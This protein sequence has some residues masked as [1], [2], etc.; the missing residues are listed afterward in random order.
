M[1]HS[2]YSIMLILSGGDEAPTF[3]SKTAAAGRHTHREK[4]SLS[5][6]HT[7]VDQPADKEPS[8]QQLLT[9]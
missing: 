9:S 7:P 4:H 6:S 1:S 2:L 3:F 5:V 8:S